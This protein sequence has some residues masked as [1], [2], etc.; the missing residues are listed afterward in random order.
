MHCFAVTAP[1]LEHLCAGEL[2]ESGIAAAAQPEPGGVAWEG[3]MVSLYRS[4]LEL[5]TAS[6]VIV[7]LGSFRARTFPELERRCAV[8]PWRE[9]VAP[10]T[11]LV[12]RVTSRKSRLYH[13]D[14]VA[15]RVMRVVADA[16]GARDGG[17]AGEE[18]VDVAG[19]RLVVIR[20][21]RDQVLVSMDSSGDRLH[22]RGYRQALAK[23]PLRETLAAA[24]LLASG[25]RGDTPLV[26]PMC[27]SGT[28]P[29]EAALLARRIAPGLASPGQQPRAY[30][31]HSWPG[32]EEAL[33]GDVVSA[34][35]G[36][37]R[38]SAGVPILGRDRNAGA[39][40]AS[41]ANAGRAGVAED[42]AFDVEPVARLA[43]PPGPGHLVTNPPYGVRVGEGASLRPLYGELGRVLREGAAGWQVTLMGA[44]PRLEAAMG[45]NLTE[46][47]RTSNGGIP[48]RI[49]A[50]GVD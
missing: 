34:A 35:R 40:A 48:V 25:W 50:G 1:G 7:R 11:P 20:L 17:V 26:D 2:A 18:D 15:E 41:R 47:V 21:L 31:V 4:N 32:H 37:V 45:L 42:V 29:I 43:L 30:A 36:R 38:E 5:R 8:L 19:A 16:A 3:D 10:G 23:A 49:L 9:Y 27:G 13:S 12:L 33:W 14:A 39:V 6:R 22:Q 28:I 44:D 24:M 46:R